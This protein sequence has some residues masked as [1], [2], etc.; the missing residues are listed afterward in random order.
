MKNNK[1]NKAV[2][3]RMVFQFLTVFIF[4]GSSV[5]MGIL[6]FALPKTGYSEIEKRKLTE[7]PKLTFTE[8]ANGNF[9]DNL[10]KYVSDNFAFRDILVDLGFKLQDK[11]GI[12]LDGVKIYSSENSNEYIIEENITT[13][14]GPFLEINALRAQT[15]SAKPGES[16]PLHLT[17]DSIVKNADLYKNLDAEDIM[18]EQ[19][20]A[21]FMVKNTALEI[22]YGNSAVAMDYC[23]FINTFKQAVGDDVTVYD[24][25]IPTHFEFG[26]PKKYKNQVGRAQKPFI[27]EIYQNLNPSVLSVDAYSNIQKHY[28][29][30]EYLYFNSDHHWTSLGAYRAYTAFSKV[31]DF[32]ATALNSFEKK[33]IEEFL[34]TFYTSTYDKNLKENPDR[35]DYYIPPCNYKVLNY[36]SSGTGTYEGT[37]LYEA[38]SGISS[39]YLVFMGGDIPLSVITT[40]N[41][42]GRSI[43]VFK[44][45]YGNAFVPFLVS[46]YDT[47][48]VA[49]I[50]TFPFNAISFVEQNDIKEVLFLNNIM[51]SCTPPRIQN[52][53]NLLQ[54]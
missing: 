20:G 25:V 14:D 7:F 26:L 24:L 31:A 50:R 11:R 38:V 8:L 27:D 13:I 29:A 49:D 21:L 5:I 28:N 48:Y 37:L 23:N 18:G 16:L 39:G 4:F 44:E 22:F 17:I 36:T 12:R 35:V 46:N 15:P 40:D 53:I 52:Y 43:L 47:V 45:S 30:G 42:T 54:K 51:T 10:T 3:L 41:N 34:G 32:K 1:N 6:F 2:V 9:T 19:R 33:T